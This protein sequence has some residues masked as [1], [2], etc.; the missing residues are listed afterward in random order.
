MIIGYARASTAEQNL[1]LQLDALT[2]AGCEQIFR[3]EGISAVARERPQFS[4]ALDALGAGDTLVIWKM[5]RAFRSLIHAL[6]VLEDLEA[7]GVN[8][9]SLTDAID[10]ATPVGRFAYQITNAFAELERALIA[11]RTKA[12]I[13]AARRRGA[14]IGRP[15]KL[16]PDQIEFAR[17]ALAAG[18]FSKAALAARFSVSRR[19]LSRALQLER[20][21]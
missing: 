6:Q 4:A 18:R 17:E 11:E 7:R 9:H 14:R 21:Q 13:D 12:G 3:D 5:D 10:T 1:D 8:F 15:R 19:T 16:L 2:A 20:R